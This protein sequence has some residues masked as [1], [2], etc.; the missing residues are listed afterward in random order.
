MPEQPYPCDEREEVRV[1][2]TPYVRFDLN[3]YSV[4]ADQVRK[5]LTVNATLDTVSILDGANVV[6]SHA[7]CGS[8]FL[9]E[10]AIHGYALNSMTK[11]LIGLLDDYGAELLKGFPIPMPSDKAYS[12]CLKSGNKNQEQITYYPLTIALM[13]W[14]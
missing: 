11:Q 5:I 14:W 9:N 8:T 3:D 13:R 4:P 6:A 1:P 7:D 2:K 12:V 10:A